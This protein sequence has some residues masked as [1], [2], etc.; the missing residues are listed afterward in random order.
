MSNNE[1]NQETN[2]KDILKV[3]SEDL[4]SNKTPSSTEDAI[5]REIRK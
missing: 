3:P 1:K 5:L 2:I 4:N